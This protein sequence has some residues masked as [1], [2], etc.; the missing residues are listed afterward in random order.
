V[1][2]FFT[3]VAGVLRTVGVVLCCTAG[4]E[5][6]FFGVFV[7][8]TRPT[9]GFVSA[10][11]APPRANAAWVVLPTTA[12]GKLT[13]T[14][15]LFGAGA[16]TVTTEGNDTGVCSESVRGPSAIS[17]ATLTLASAPAGIHAR[18]IDLAP[19]CSLAP[20]QYRP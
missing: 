2:F 13:A 15:L 20:A 10:V 11:D 3:G 14:A 19:S 7:A 16:D 6:G 4:A 12:A 8:E 9:V 18:F 1:V 17:P 5:G